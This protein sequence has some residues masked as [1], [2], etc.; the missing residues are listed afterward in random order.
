MTSQNA[1]PSI[2][3]GHVT[4]NTAQLDASHAFLTDLG[5]RSIFKG[6]DIAVLELRGG[7]HLVLRKKA[8]P[9]SGEADFDL[10]VEDLEATHQNLEA[11]GFSPSPIARGRIHNSFWVTDPGGIQI[12]LNSSHV[13]N[14]AV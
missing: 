5:M 3:I 12:R 1:R 6:E 7:T 13:G 14:R 2:W 10:M 9:I 4:L 11:Q 8:E